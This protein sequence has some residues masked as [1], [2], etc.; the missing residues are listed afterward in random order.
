MYN[1]LTYLVLRR[2][3]KRWILEH[4]TRI[5]SNEIVEKTMIAVNYYN[6]LL[7]FAY[8]HIYYFGLKRWQQTLIPWLF[9]SGKKNENCL[10]IVQKIRLMVSACKCLF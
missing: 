9:T 5:S 7:P 1:N 2:Y 4:K 10:S 6:K 8:N 3:I